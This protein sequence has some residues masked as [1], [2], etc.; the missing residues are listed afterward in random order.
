MKKIVILFCLP[1][2]LN[3]CFEIE[4]NC[5]DFKTGTFN[6]SYTINDQKVKGQFMRN[7]TLSVDYYNG[8]TDSSSVRWINDCEF[9]LKT[10]NP[11]SL[12]EKEPLHF[13]IL[14][15]TDSSYTFSYQYAIKKANRPYFLQKG[16]AVKAD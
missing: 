13:K 5:E 11:K 9:I 1:L 3:S 10:I 6:F 8:K 12:A 2:L 16:V 4:R 7:D 15:T 14:T